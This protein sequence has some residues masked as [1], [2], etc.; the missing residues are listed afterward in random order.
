ME[1]ISK[2][3]IGEIVYIPFEIEEIHYNK[4]GC[5]YTVKN[6]DD[7]NFVRFTVPCKKIDECTEK[8]R[9]MIEAV[10]SGYDK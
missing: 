6:D 3:S 4:K 2:Y 1:V 9:K 5:Q 10:M 8:I 7:E